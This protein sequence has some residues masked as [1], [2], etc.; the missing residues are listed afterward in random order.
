MTG[1]SHAGR[2]QDLSPGGHK[3]RVEAQSTL[4]PYVFEGQERSGK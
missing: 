2:R 1:V 3:F 4:E